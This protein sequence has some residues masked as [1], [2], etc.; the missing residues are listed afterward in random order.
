[1]K[2][3]ILET[4]DTHGYIFPGNYLVRGDYSD[5]FGL[6]RAKTVF[7]QV[8]HS[9][10][11]GQVVSIENGDTL[12]G[13]ALASYMTHLRSSAAIAD[14]QSAYNVLDY[15]FGVL[16]N[17]DFNY[18]TELL[19]ANFAVA[20]RKLINANIIDK[21]TRQP[22][23][24]E[25][26][27][28][29][30]RGGLKIAVIGVTT[31][32][33]PH[34][35]SPAHIHNLEFLD[36]VDT[37]KRIV[38]QVR[39]H[40]DLVIVSYHGG[41]ESDLVTGEP[42]ER[43]TGENQ[44]YAIL[45]E[46]A[47][48]DVLLTGH[49]H[50]EIATVVNDVVV[51]Q[52]GYQAKDVAMVEI[53]YEFEDGQAVIKKKTPQLLKTA[54]YEVDHKLRDQLTMFND[55]V[56]DWLDKPVGSLT[57]PLKL[58]SGAK[59]RIND[60]PYLNF[61]HQVQLSL[62]D[63][64]ISAASIIKEDAPGLPQQVSKR[65][66]LLNYPYSNQLVKLELSGAQLRSILEYTATF[67]VKNQRTGEISFA[68]KFLEPKYQLYHFDS[69]YPIN[70]QIEVDRP[71]GTRVTRLEFN[72][73]PITDQQIFTLVVSKYRAMG[74]GTYPVYPDLKIVAEYE[75]EITEIMEDYL[76]HNSPV[77]VERAKNYRI[78]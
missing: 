70:Y 3:D 30:E 20:N 77:K 8:Y 35:E 39:K 62:T 9:Y 4:S 47:G 33:I 65:Y 45:Q 58:E 59:A 25:E 43:I 78:I 40:A 19:T 74:G 12:Q 51:V 34:W 60:D 57:E 71:L 22:F 66:L 13:S 61:I 36:V 38:P 27:A 64:D 10:G 69:F 49:Q 56:E 7:D 24:G 16:G 32:Y 68:K 52:P 6:L 42:T 44:G 50:R 15:D 46:V 31:K 23:M 2:L 67:F 26:F 18:G 21:S 72:G 1:M 37:L 14:F 11:R 5:S 29:I 17:H 75:P 55:A 54:N 73:Q 76:R 48:I 53:E 63:A 41:F 28:L